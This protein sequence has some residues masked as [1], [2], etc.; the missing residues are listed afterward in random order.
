MATAEGP[1]P[2]T[3][4][5]TRALSLVR[6]IEIESLSGLAMTTIAW[7]D[8]M[9][10]ALDFDTPLR[11]G[12]VPPVGGR[13]GVSVNVGVEDAGAGCV[14]VGVGE[15]VAVGGSLTMVFVGVAVGGAASSVSVG[16]GDTV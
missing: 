7:S 12:G 6:K 13:L 9:A 11:I 3:T 1:P 10:A 4:R 8:D 15:N 14:A 2:V 16:V 5:A